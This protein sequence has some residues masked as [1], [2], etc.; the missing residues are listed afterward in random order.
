M[1]EKNM[2]TTFRVSSVSCLLLLVII[3]QGDA[4]TDQSLGDKY[5]SSLPSQEL[6]S[7]ASSD[8]F[9]QKV[10]T[11]NSNEVVVCVI[12]TDISNIEPDDPKPNQSLSFLEDLNNYR[13]GKKAEIYVSDRRS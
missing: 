6:S 8:A 11:L 3:L 1:E 13:I 7:S 12:E 4:W 2:N 10:I 5:I 9:Y